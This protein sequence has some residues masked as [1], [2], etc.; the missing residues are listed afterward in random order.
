M[1]KMVNQGGEKNNTP[2][3]KIIVKWLLTKITQ[4][5]KNAFITTLISTKAIKRYLMLLFKSVNT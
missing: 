5:K 4:L 1:R 3:P 2:C